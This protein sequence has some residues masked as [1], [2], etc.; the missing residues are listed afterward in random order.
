MAEMDEP[1]AFVDGEEVLHAVAQARRDIGG[2]IRK[3]LR[4]VARGPAAEAILQRLRQVPVIQR[5]KRRDAVRQQLVDKAVV[6]IEAFWVRRAGPLREDARPGNR[7]SIGLCAQRLHQLDVFLE[8]AIMV[9]RGIP[10]AAIGY[11]PGR[12][13][14]TVPD[15]WAA[16]ILVY[17][18][19][20]LIGRGRCAPQETV[21]KSGRGCS[22]WCGIRVR[23]GPT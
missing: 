22:S 23:L 18:S 19:L 17:G 11:G 20:D 15:R 21:R 2:V 5:R 10:V 3:C 8:Q 1:G 6:E 14:E 12:V 7:E 4:R 9:G 13:R 16:A